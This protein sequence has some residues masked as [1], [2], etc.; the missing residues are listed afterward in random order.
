MN[1]NNNNDKNDIKLNYYL[2]IEKND[3]IFMNL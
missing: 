2:K 1:K 3:I